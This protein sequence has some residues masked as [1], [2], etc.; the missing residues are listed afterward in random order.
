MCTYIAKRKKILQTSRYER[1]E[2]VLLEWFQQK[3][4]LNIPIQGQMFKDK[5]EEIVLKLNTEFTLDIYHI[6][7]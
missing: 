2:S 7:T 4:T 6:Y 1:T 3:W 5:A